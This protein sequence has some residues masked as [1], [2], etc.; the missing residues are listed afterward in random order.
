MIADIKLER[1]GD[2]Q[3]PPGLYEGGLPF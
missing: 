2:L 1:R 3:K